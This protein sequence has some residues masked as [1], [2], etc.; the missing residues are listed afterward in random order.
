[1]SDDLDAL[2]RELILDHSKHPQHFGL[3]PDADHTGTSHQKNPVC[4]DEITLRAR[5]DGEQIADVTWEGRGC[6]ISQASAS[7]LADL[8]GEEDLSR[9]EAITLI[10]GF[11]EALRSRG[12]IE[13]DEDVYGDAAALTG[14]SKFSARVKCAMLAWVALEDALA[15]A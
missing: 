7:M 2:Y 1:M 6:S 9:G 8:V 3:A 12:Q 4:G 11:R 14:V 10:E 5:V 15:K 13:L